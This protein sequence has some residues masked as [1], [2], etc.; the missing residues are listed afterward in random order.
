MA[1]ADRETS[2]W[3]VMLS[4]GMY[5]RNQGKLVRQLTA[6]AIALALA[7]GLWQLWAA[8]LLDLQPEGLRWGL[9]GLLGGLCAWFTFR[10]INYPP[11][12]EFLVDVE[13]ELA[14]VTWPL[15]DELQRATVVVLATM[16]LFSVVLFTYDVV[17][18]QLLR[19][20]GIL[21]FG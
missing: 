5:K 13:G 18:Q 10:I 11:F 14:K 16:F 19:W 15:K 4:P 9:L 1:R 2:F 17:W 21:Q 3:G 8:V 7:L 12:A 20:I 6:A